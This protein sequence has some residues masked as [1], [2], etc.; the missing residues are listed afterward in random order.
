MVWSHIQCC[1]LS[2]QQAERGHHG[3]PPGPGGGRQIPSRTDRSD[4]DQDEGFVDIAEDEEQ[5]EGGSLLQKAEGHQ[6]G[7]QIN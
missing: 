2:V 6:A 7:M 3:V 1:H 4:Q 5:S